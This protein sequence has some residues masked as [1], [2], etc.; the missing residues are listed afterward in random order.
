MRAVHVRIGHDDDLVVAGL[1]DVEFRLA[2]AR[3]DG[4]NDLLDDVAGQHMVFPGFLH[5]QNFAP[6]R[7]YRLEAPVPALLGRTACGVA[8]HQVHFAH[9]RIVFGAVR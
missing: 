2:D 1:A 7:Q 5:V 9:G 3:A 6:K 4:G 8:L